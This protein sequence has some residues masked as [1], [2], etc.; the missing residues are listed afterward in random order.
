MIYYG[1]LIR[2]LFISVQDFRF[3]RAAAE[4]PRRIGS[5]GVSPV[6]LLPQESP[7]CPPISS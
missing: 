7:S 4:P 5:C 1:L 2:P 6:P 3:P